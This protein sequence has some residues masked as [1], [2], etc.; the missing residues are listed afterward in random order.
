MHHHRLNIL[1]SAGLLLSTG[2]AAFAGP[3][4]VEPLSLDAGST[5]D[6]AMPTGGPSPLK[7]IRGRFAVPTD[8]PGDFEDMFIINVVQPIQFC[9][10]TISNLNTTN[11]C[12]EDYSPHSGSNFNTQVW[13]FKADG[14]GLLANDDSAGG[15]PGLSRM[16]HT[17]T[18]GTGAM[19]VTPG[20][21]YIA[22][23]GGPQRDPVSAGGLIFNQ[24]SV[25]EVSGPDG[26]G[27]TQPIVGWTGAGI[28]NVQYEM[29]LCGV[30]PMPSIPTL[31]QWGLITL[32]ALLGLAGAAMIARRPKTVPVH[33]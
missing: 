31:S 30:D 29:T 6:T 4:F 2:L 17:A 18:D 3:D 33:G 10:Q 19:V 12:G 24:S 9:V 16:G 11:C 25:T 27:G 1:L 7:S 26:P 28:T 8:G 21:Y 5:P 20:L 15:S 22:I 32:T 14:R 23:S 13:L